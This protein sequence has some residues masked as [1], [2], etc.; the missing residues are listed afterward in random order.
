MED[1]G[2]QAGE[3]GFGQIAYDFF[4]DIV[5][6][7]ISG[8]APGFDSAETLAREYL[9][10]PGYADNDARIL[11]L[12]AWEKRKNFMSG[13]VTSAGGAV[14]LPVSMTVGMGVSWL[15]QARLAAT[16][17][18]IYGHSPCEDRVKTAIG[19]AILG[20]ALK[21]SVKY[22]GV[23][24]TGKVLMKAIGKM[25]GRTLA[26]INQKIGIRLLTKAGSKGLFNFAKMVPLV[27]GVVGGGID[28]WW[29]GK[30][31]QK[32]MELFCTSQSGIDDSGI[33]DADFTEEDLES[34]MGEV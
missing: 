8:M 9:D 25:S 6:R 27:S 26:K 5:G 4:Q 15:I 21:T 29:C 34:M 2:G 16:I 20:D 23:N 14:T 18:I 7:G 31:G 12:I 3:R 11:S 13:L 33:I 19:M 28:A 30:T 32:A 1:Q 24:L 10:D 17:A 22:K